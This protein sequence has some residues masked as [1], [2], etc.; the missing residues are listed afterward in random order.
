MG[1]DSYIEGLTVSL[2][3]RHGLVLWEALALVLG[4]KGQQKKQTTTYSR[5]ISSW[6]VEIR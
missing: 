1:S 4:G 3:D 6:L 5:R 2:K